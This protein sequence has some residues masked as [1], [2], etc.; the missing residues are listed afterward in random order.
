MASTDRSRSS[1]DRILR[2][3]HHHY[4]EMGACENVEKTHER[5]CAIQASDCEPTKLDEDNNLKGEK[6]SSH[7]TLR[8]RGISSSCSCE[9]TSIGA[10]IE[11]SNNVTASGDEEWVYRCAPHQ[12]SCQLYEGEPFSF[13]SNLPTTNTDTSCTCASQKES[14]N[15][16]TLYGACKKDAVPATNTTE[17]TFCAYSPN[18]CETG[19]VW[20]PP[21]SVE[22]N[23]SCD[24]RN[25]RIGG[26][27]GDAKFLHC[28]ITADDCSWD[29]NYV[30]PVSL[31]QTFGTQ[32]R[33]CKPSIKWTNNTGSGSSS[34]SGATPARKAGITFVA[35]GCIALLAVLV[36]VFKRVR[37][38]SSAKE[39]DFAS[40]LEAPSQ[41]S[42]EEVTLGSGGAKPTANYKDGSDTNELL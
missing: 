21:V 22:S 11:P 2:D 31:E 19:Y 7:Y 14:S 8:E 40:I 25:V 17:D 32:C 35:V 38:Y 18:D 6:W 42:L 12:D 34:S 27:V 39:I 9:R 16:P 3:G 24:C 23:H 20:Q 13:V 33:L 4:A 37:R 15:L 10:C 5:R 36:L 30:P 26:C 28:A 1:G 29:H 41:D